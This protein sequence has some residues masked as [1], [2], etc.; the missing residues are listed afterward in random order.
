MRVEGDLLRGD[1][2][3]PVAVRRERDVMRGERDRA[4]GVDRLDEHHTTERGGIGGLAY[5]E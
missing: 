1:H 4:G 5:E 3:V 2:R